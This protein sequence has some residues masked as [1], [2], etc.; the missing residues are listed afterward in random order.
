MIL[1]KQNPLSLKTDILCSFLPR[2]FPAVKIKFCGHGKHGSFSFR[3]LYRNV[4]IHH[5]C[6]IA[7]NGQSQTAPSINTGIF[8]MLLCKNFKYFWQKIFCDTNSIIGNDCGQ[9]YSSIRF[10]L[11]NRDVDI[12]T[13]G[14]EFHRIVDQIYHDLF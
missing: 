11:C 6:I 7:R 3:T 5:P 2:L 8:F 1:N 13:F 12:S 9:L 14:G 4:T 10:L